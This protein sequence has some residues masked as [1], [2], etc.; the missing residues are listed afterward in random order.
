MTDSSRCRT[1]NMA[2]QMIVSFKRLNIF[3]KGRHRLVCHLKILYFCS[4]FSYSHILGG[5]LE[6]SLP[7]SSGAEY[8]AALQFL[9]KTLPHT[10]HQ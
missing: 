4:V 3:E 9:W 5:L 10:K 6:F 8:R 7:E 2:K 1:A